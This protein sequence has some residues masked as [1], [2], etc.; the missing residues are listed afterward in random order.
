MRRSGSPG[1]SQLAGG[2]PLAAAQELV[3]R[4]YLRMDVGLSTPFRF[5]RGKIAGSHWSTQTVATVMRTAH[6][7]LDRR[8]RLLD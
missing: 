5:L 7:G 3:P 4:R 6:L 2:D 8:K 1:P